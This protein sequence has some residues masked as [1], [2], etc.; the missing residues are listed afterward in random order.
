MKV[1]RDVRLLTSHVTQTE[2]TL[3]DVMRLLTSHVTQT[4][5]MLSSLQIYQ[6]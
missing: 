3:R 1:G 5:P 4:E 2:P 6:K